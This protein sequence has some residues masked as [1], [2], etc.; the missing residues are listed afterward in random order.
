MAAA[1]EPDP[2]RR[3]I[4]LLR[5]GAEAVLVIS[6]KPPPFPCHLP[7]LWVQSEWGKI[8]LDTVARLSEGQTCR[9]EPDFGEFARL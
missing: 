8:L 6:Q 3:A 9:F 4:S 1:G 2:S 5:N 7:V